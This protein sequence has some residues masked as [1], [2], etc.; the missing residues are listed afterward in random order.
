[1][2]QIYFKLI[3][4]EKRTVEQV[5]ENIRA[6]VQALLDEHYANSTV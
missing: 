4:A 5:P 2:I 3:L 6:D 1:M